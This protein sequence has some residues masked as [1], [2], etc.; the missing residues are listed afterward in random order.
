MTALIDAN[1]FMYAAGA[2]HPHKGPCID[3]LRRIARKAVDGVADAETL[4]E[5][6]HR[7]RAL[8]RWVLGRDVHDSAVA[9]VSSILPI[10]REDLDGARSLLDRHASLKAREALHAAVAIRHGIPT[11]YSYDTDFDVIEGI[12]RR[13]PPADP[14]G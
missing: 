2:P 9:T 10:T 4:Q 7:Y 3:F 14:S 1:I 6:L 8:N 12:D 11:I 5:I 13:E